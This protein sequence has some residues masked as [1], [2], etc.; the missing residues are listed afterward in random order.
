MRSHFR[1]CNL[2][3][4]STFSNLFPTPS[5]V[6]VR[7][8]VHYLKLYNTNERQPGWEINGEI[9]FLFL[10]RFHHRYGTVRVAFLLLFLV[11]L[12]SFILFLLI[13]ISKRQ[14]VPSPVSHFTILVNPNIDVI[15]NE[16]GCFVS[17]P[18]HDEICFWIYYKSWKKLVTLQ[19]FVFNG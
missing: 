15:S 13:V 17:F 6:E 7:K 3:C 11:P 10:H 18:F 9:D 4:E 12:F 16:S 2:S 14:L 19:K 5:Y 8:K 1:E